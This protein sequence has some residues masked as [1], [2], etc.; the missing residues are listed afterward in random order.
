M[1][2]IIRMP[3]LETYNYAELARSNGSGDLEY[4]ENCSY[5][6]YFQVWQVRHNAGAT[7]Y[8]HITRK[9]ISIGACQHLWW[10]YMSLNVA[11]ILYYIIH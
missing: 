10:T 5:K 11:T 3:H 9:S 7:C 4:G 2:V 6:E 8:H 1:L